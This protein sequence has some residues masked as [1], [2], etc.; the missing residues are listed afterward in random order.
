MTLR[1]TLLLTAAALLLA[2]GAA[3]GSEYADSG[4]SDYGDIDSHFDSG[5]GYSG[6][7][8]SGDGYSGDGEAEVEDNK[9]PGEA[10]KDA[11]LG[12][13]GEAALDGVGGLMNRWFAGKGG[14]GGRKPAPKVCS[15]QIL[16]LTFADCGGRRLQKKCGCKGR[17]NRG[18]SPPICGF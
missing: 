11:A 5:D 3:D 8:Y 9:S 1:N 10:I 17:K 4:Y 18:K 2:V 7:G 15:K 16:D 12:A 6:D 13:A 14:D